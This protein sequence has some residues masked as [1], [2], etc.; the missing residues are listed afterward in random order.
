MNTK[1]QETSYIYEPSPYILFYEHCFQSS[2]SHYQYW[3]KKIYF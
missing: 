2:P 1:F 3:Y